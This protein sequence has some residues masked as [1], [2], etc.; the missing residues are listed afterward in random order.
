MAAPLIPIVVGGL[1]AG[2]GWLAGK[3]ASGGMELLTKKEYTSTQTTDS[4]QYTYSPTINRTYDLQYNIASGYQSSISTKKE[5]A[6][7]QQP[8]TT[9]QIITIPTTSQGG[10]V[11]ASE[12][13]S[14]DYMTLAIFGA[15]GFGAYYFLTKKGANK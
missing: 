1:L 4:R 13:G 10:S 7:T 12:T 8:T 3:S 15:L 14:F 11:G 5:Q 6:I 9:P 2:G